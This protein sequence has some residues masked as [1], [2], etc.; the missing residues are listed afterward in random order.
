MVGIIDEWVRAYVEDGWMGARKVRGEEQ[1]G[2]RA[3][4]LCFWCFRG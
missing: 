1:A 4:G 3:A 2:G